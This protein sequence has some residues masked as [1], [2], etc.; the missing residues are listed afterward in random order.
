MEHLAIMKKSWG[1]TDKILTGEKTVE[2]RWYK[3]RR[4]PWDK[5]KTGDRVFFKDTA[6][7]VRVKATVAKVLQFANLT[8]EKTEE[9]M[10]QYGRADLGT[11]HIMPEIRG[12]VKGKK[13]CVL[14]FLNNPVEVEPFEVDKT[15]FGAMSAWI[16]VDNIERIRK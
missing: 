11:N 14:V 8:S 4:A 3:S 1:L 16:S 13:Y 15:G 6:G 9:I 10:V 5:I 7:P 2:S 12:Y